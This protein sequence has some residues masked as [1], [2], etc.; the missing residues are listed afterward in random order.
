MTANDGAGTG[1]EDL[2]ALRKEIDELKSIPEEQLI[3]PAPA[4]LLD[5]EPTPHPTNAIGSEQRD[6]SVDE[7]TLDD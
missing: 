6:K 3:S 1:H 5:R 7:E 2:D 4:D